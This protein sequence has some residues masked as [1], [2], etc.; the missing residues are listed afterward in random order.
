MRTLLVTKEYP[1]TKGG[2]A[3]YYYNLAGHFPLHETFLVMHNN[4]LELDSNRGFFSWRH[5]FGVI[6]RKIKKSNIDHVLVGHILPLGT[7]VFCLSFLL[8][9][10]YS[11]FLHGLD[12]SCALKKGRKRFI[13]TL[14]LKRA[15]TIIAANS[16]VASSLIKAVPSLADRVSV[17][18]PGLPKNHPFVSEREKTVMIKKYDLKNKTILFSLGRLVKRKGV[19]Q[20]IKALSSMT[21]DELS[22]LIYIVAGDGPEKEKLKELVPIRL[23]DKIIFLGEIKEEEKWCLLSLC[24]IFIMPARN[25]HGDYEGFGIVYLEANLFSK[26]VIAGMAGGVSDAVV[27]NLNG[28]LID[29]ESV[30]EIKEAIISLKN[31]EALRNLLGAQGKARAEKEF[32]WEKLSHD[33]YNVIK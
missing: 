4:N 1:P 18:N 3:N 32:N 33:L 29:P 22:N 12:L 20:V 19:D 17:I 15:K 6:Y 5:S 24:D 2:V 23:K 21:D 14:I 10:S 7:T 8:P 11:V 27:N 13:S 26:P 16:F 25:I 28:L 31:N 9:F 30:T